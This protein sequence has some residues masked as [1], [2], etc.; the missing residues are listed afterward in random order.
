MAERR[1]ATTMEMPAEQR[2]D[3][4]HHHENRDDAAENESGHEQNVSPRPIHLGAGVSRAL[5]ADPT[6]TTPT[7]PR[8]NL[9]AI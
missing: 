9:G 6:L 5:W 7:F 3:K 1:Y 8:T 2:P 4:P